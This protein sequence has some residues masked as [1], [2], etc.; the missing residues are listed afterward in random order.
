MRSLAKVNLTLEVVNKRT[1]GYHD[2]ES[3]FALVK[4]L[5]DQL[6]IKE[7]HDD[8]I[9]I[10]IK[11]GSEWMWEKNIPTDERNIVYKVLDYLRKKHNIKKGMNVVIH[12]NIPTE[13]GLGGGSSNAATA[14]KWFSVHF[15]VELDLNELSRIGADIPFFIVGK[16]AH[17]EGIGEIIKP[18][19]SHMTLLATLVKP[20]FGSCTKE[21]YKSADICNAQYTQKVI[22]AI[23]KDDVEAVIENMY[24][25]FN[26]LKDVEKKLYEVGFSKVVMSGSGSTFICFGNANLKKLHKEKYWATKVIIG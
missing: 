14:A 17:V 2:I 8:K 12:K 13:A 1:D 26:I 19:E 9:H 21:A 22:D 23:K 16:I 25:S 15:G 20:P 24:N 10:N 18:I 7:S 5:F 4:D 6:E 3:V 11:Y